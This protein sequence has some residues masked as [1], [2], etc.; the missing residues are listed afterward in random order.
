MD[1]IFD[2]TR[3]ID[4][5]NED[6]F[7]KVKSKFKLS[8]EYSFNGEHSVYTIGNSVTFYIPV[9]VYSADAFT[10]ELLHVFM[11]YHEVYIGG[12]F[13]N[14]MWKSN[15][16]KKLLDLPLSEH[17]TNCIAH[18]LMLPIY[19]ERGFERSVFLLDYHEFKTEPGFIGQIS[20]YYRQGAL[21]N[22]S[23][24]KNFIGKFFAFK[25]DPNPTFKYDA[26]LLQL[27]KIDTQLYQIMEAY[28]MRWA[29]YDFTTDK[30]S[31]YRGINSDLYD[32]LKPWMNGKRFG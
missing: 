12:N 1:R 8:F 3:L 4:S 17:I 16:L 29:D 24:I 19:L 5:R 14:T 6:L 11:D 15:T 31:E 2:H 23:A 30:L 32:A 20:R 22:I 13:K 7:E 25:C 26:E 18:I 10:H 28:F 9:G 21:Y 27:S